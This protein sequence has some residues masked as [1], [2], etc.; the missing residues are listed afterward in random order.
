MKVNIPI[1]SSMQ[2]D[3]IKITERSLARNPSM[4]QSPWKDHD[5]A[6]KPWWSNPTTSS[7]FFFY[8]CLYDFELFVK[9]H[10]DP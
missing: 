10:N 5:A 3:D 4:S 9:H 8:I 6:L 2:Y 1:T 7:D